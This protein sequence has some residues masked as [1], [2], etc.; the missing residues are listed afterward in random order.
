MTNQLKKWRE[1]LNYSQMEL[2]VAAKISH[3][4]VVSIEKYGYLPGPYVR[5]KIAKTMNLSESVIWPGTEV[6]EVAV[7]GNNR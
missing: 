6:Q 7:D 2:S 1:K 4:T 5:F 3:A